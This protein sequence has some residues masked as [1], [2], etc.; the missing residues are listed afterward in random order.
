[1]VAP[2]TATITA[3]DPVSGI[4]STASAGDAAL[5]VLGELQSIT[6]KP[7]TAQRSVGEVQNYVATGNYEGGG[8]QNITQ[9]VDFTSSDPAVASAPNQAPNKGAVTMVAPGTAQI[10]V[11]D[12]VSGMESTAGGG[13]ATVTVLGPIERLEIS[14][15]TATTNVGKTPVF[16]VRG[17]FEGGGE[18][19]LTQAVTYASSNPAVLEAPNEQG[20]KSRMRAVAVGSATI[21][22]TDPTSSLSVDAAVTVAEAAAPTPTSG[23]TPGLIC[24]D[25]DGNGSVAVTDGVRILRNAGGLP[26]E[27][28]P[29]RCDA[30][31]SGGI[32][33]TD[34]V[35]V[36]RA[37]AGLPADLGC[38]D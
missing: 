37:A 21:T 2:G 4:T 27:C 3:R 32:G 5:T 30:D 34:G 8:T 26:S 24:G 10:S 29:L 16:S 9:K 38:G 19:N 36:L 15:A 35:L 6:L 14:P 22:A 23:A 18:K 12:P 33:V 7:L 31:S 13:D 20:N 17:I 25:A 1:M 28:T 11:K